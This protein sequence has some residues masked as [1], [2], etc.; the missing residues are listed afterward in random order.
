[1]YFSTP[2]HMGGFL[3]VYKIFSF[4]V[5]KEKVS[6]PIYNEELFIF[7]LCKRHVSSPIHNEGDCEFSVNNF[8]KS[9]FFGPFF[10]YRWDAIF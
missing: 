9:L 3:F 4:R 8:E 2:I 5:C 7:L 6:I 1:M 10:D